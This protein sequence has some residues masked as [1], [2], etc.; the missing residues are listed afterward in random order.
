MRSKVAG[1][2]I[3]MLLAANI[4]LPAYA[5]ETGDQAP[6]A[7]ICRGEVAADIFIEA[8]KV[9]EEVG[10]TAF[11]NLVAVDLCRAIRIQAVTLGEKYKEYMDFNKELTQVFLVEGTNKIYVFILFL[12][13]NTTGE[14]DTHETHA[15][16]GNAEVRYF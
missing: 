5:W 2:V 11:R 16:A 12:P 8:D 13:T 14:P 9:S 1:F 10:L 3:A 4:A 15:H 7:F 6:V